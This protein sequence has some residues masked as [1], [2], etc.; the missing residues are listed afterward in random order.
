[1]TREEADSGLA[2]IER[3]LRAEAGTAGA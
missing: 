3:A 2:I 1:L